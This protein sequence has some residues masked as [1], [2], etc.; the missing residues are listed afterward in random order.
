MKIDRKEITIGELVA[1]YSDDD[2]GGVLGYS[3]QLDIRPPY[4]RE[5]VY[6]DK[7]R[8]DVIRSVLA[9]FP[10]NV[11]YWARRPDGRHE[12][13]D[14]QQR[15][16]SICQYVT[17]V[18]AINDKYFS[19]Q[20]DDVQDSINGYTLTIYQCDGKPSEKLDWFRIVNIAGER[21]YDQELRNAVYAGPWVSDAKRYFS[22]HVS[23]AKFMSSEYVRASA[24]R[25]E[26]LETAIRWAC[27]DAKKIDDYMARHQHDAN[28]NELW[29]HF[30]AVIG[31]IAKTFPQERRAIMQGVDWGKLYAEH[32]SRTLDSDAL[33]REISKLL[34]LE[35]PGRAN[36]IQRPS[37]IFPY[38]LDGD[39][40]H[41][42]LRTFTKGQ[43]L[44]AYE[45]LK[46]KCEHCGQ[47]FEFRD[48]E[49][50]HKT[51]WDDGGLTTDDNLQMLCR[52]CNR[53]KGAN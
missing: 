4:Q 42:N 34:A 13:L 9:G 12:V 24:I 11:M 46:G 52:K 45:R 17:G 40:R 37:G 6:K 31:W 21:L 23:V 50:D 39:E 18:F 15:T 14:G 16:I 25:Q 35:Q 48:M 3:G 27:G 1:G 20:P 51:P 41:L 22:G 49:G 10:L 44:A 33:E 53:T 26:L 5:F 2:E 7:Q 28:A 8:D 30:R 47:H 19:N 38:V 36:A 43:K 32:G 29:E